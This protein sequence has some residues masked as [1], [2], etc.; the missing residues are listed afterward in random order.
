LFIAMLAFYEVPERIRWWHDDRPT[1]QVLFEKQL[2][3]FL[4]EYDGA[5]REETRDKVWYRTWEWSKSYVRST[6]TEIDNWRGRVDPAGIVEHHGRVEI[7]I[8]SA[9]SGVKIAYYGELTPALASKADVAGL[10]T[11]DKVVFSGRLKMGI[12]DLGLAY[13]A[14]FGVEPIG[15]N[16][17][18]GS[19]LLISI[20]TL[21]KMR[22]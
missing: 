2:G 13:K 17:L 18:K 8:V 15:S 12:G 7:V 14:P 6:G 20:D 16:L 5:W 22:N 11:W 9:Y 19:A 1:G 4:R 10:R 21:E 3:G